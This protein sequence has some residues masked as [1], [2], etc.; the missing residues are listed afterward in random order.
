MPF[1]PFHWGPASQIGLPAVGFF[2]ASESINAYPNPVTEITENKQG[3]LTTEHTESCCFL[4]V[5]CD[6]RGFTKKKIR[7]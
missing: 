1:T 5:L 2:N 3:K 4:C 7:L 6:L